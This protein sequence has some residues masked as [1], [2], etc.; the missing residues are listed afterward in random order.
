MRFNAENFD[1]NITQAYIL[2]GVHAENS[3]VVNFISTFYKYIDVFKANSFTKQ[4][5]LLL[6]NQQVVLEFPQNLNLIIKIISIY[7]EGELFYQNEDDSNDIHY[8]HGSGDAISFMQ[9]NKNI[10]VRSFNEEEFGFYVIYNLRPEEN[11]DDINYGS[12]ALFNLEKDLNE[13]IDFPLIY[14]TKLNN[15]NQP[16][17]FNIKILDLD[18]DKDKNDTFEKDTNDFQILGV[19]TSKNIVLGKKMN[20]YVNPDMSD[21]K[22]GSF[23]QALNIGKVH[24]SAEDIQNFI[25]NEKE[26]GRGNEDKY[27]Y[28]T[29][30]KS[31]SNKHEYRKIASDIS[32][33]P[34]NNIKY[35]AYIRQ[36]NFGNILEDSNNKYNLVSDNPKATVMKI[37]FA[38][39]YKNIDFSITSPDETD[40]K[41][42]MTFIKSEYIYGRSV[43]LVEIKKTKN[44]HLNV[45]L[46]DNKN[47]IDNEKL[48]IVFKYDV[49]ESQEQSEEGNSLK[50][51]KID[52]EFKETTLKL[53]VKPMQRNNENINAS[54]S[55]RVIPQDNAHEE[56]ILDSI[57]LYQFENE[58]IYNKEVKSDVDEIE[59]VINDFPSNKAFYY[60]T[61]FATALDSKECLAYELI[62][63]G[64]KNGVFTPGVSA[65]FRVMMFIL[66]GAIGVLI[67][68]LVIVIIR[69]KKQNAALEDEVEVLK[70]NFDDDSEKNKSKEK[71][72]SLLGKD[73]E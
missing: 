41:K 58:Y 50:E 38:K 2:V 64:N 29:I 68:V 19:V 61:V 56:E 9:K 70:I 46:K 6:K 28:V 25:N 63:I 23:D 65:K 47:K 39:N 49:F 54:Y 31:P 34:S 33:L 48:N 24:F 44:V 55:V 8:L 16:V 32:I 57:S 22:Y 35:K 53:K 37:E 52:Y 62:T 43:I 67:L 10:V 7:G 15:N 5:F 59:I 27:L 26:E 51:Q 20:Q 21:A 71:K 18:Y 30:S 36:Y 12:S 40:I 45:F 60:V 1:K 4:I 3:T 17:D 66:F 42:N 73:D 13:K 14:Y 69:M 11:Y 72:V